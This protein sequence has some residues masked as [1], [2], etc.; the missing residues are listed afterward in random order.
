MGLRCLF[1]CDSTRSLFRFP[2][3]TWLRAKWL[4]FTHFEES[5]INA[6]SRLCHRHF[7]KYCFTNFEMVAA[8]FAIN[9]QLSDTA[10]PTIYT[11]G[12][13]S[14][15]SRPATKDVGCQCDPSRSFG[16]QVRH[17]MV[18]RRSKAIQ[19]HPVAK[20][21]ST[22]RDVC[23]KILDSSVCTSVPIKRQRR[24]DIGCSSFSSPASTSSTQSDS[25]FLPDDTGN[26]TMLRSDRLADNVPKS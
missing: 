6:S 4:E 22:M 16:T 12:A 2:T 11:V 14:S 3:L 5:G 9:L 13:S 20:R 15:P 7:S 25:T 24:K 1:G 17:A 19:V 21:E 26:T 18:L 10:V 23:G 8:G